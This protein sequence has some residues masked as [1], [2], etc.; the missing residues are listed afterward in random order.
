MKKSKKVRINWEN[1]FYIV[2]SITAIILAIVTVK[3]GNAIVKE[4]EAF[5]K[6]EEKTEVVSDYQSYIQLQK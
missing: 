3:V 4:C 6:S 5:E 1:V 2:A